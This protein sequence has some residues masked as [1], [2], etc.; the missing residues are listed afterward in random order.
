MNFAVAGYLH[1]ANQI[2]VT[3]AKK[4]DNFEPESLL[5]ERCR[6]VRCTQ[7]PHPIC[8]RVSCPDGGDRGYVLRAPCLFDVVCSKETV[9]LLLEPCEMAAM[10]FILESLLVNSYHCLLLTLGA[11]AAPGHIVTRSSLVDT[12][13]V[14]VILSFSCFGAP[15]SAF[16]L[17]ASSNVIRTL[18]FI[19]DFWTRIL[20]VNAPP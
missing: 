9:R 19:R 1:K 3:G 4:L 15:C 17:P 18:C 16:G 5:D 2:H 14:H 6:R 11:L 10:F 20:P 13:F 7:L 12:R 8:D